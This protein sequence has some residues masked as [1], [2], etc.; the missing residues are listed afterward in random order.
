MD[1]RAHYNRLIERAKCRSILPGIYFEEHHIIPKCLG[2]T[3]DSENLVKL[4]P[5]EH[6]VAH[7]LLVKI[8][9]KEYKLLYA[10]I[11]MTGEKEFVSRNN[12]AYA[13]IKKRLSESKKGKQYSEESKLKMSESAKK[14]KPMSK[15][16]RQKMSASRLGKKKGPMS[17]EQKE[18]IRI[19]KANNPR[20]AW[21]KG[22]PCSEETKQKLREY[23]S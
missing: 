21:N 23:Y 18:K 1:Y 8:H 12:K 15:E 20:P 2:G 3:N 19:T 4:F 9:P 11:I 22:I 5:E 10:L 16:T 17:E 13:W 14:R 6:Y 7:Q